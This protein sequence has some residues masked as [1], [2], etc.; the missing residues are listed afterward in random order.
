M[1]ELDPLPGDPNI[2]T[3][4]KALREGKRFG[5]RI[6]YY[7]L[8]MLFLPMVVVFFLRR[9]NCEYFYEWVDKDTF[10]YFFSILVQVASFF[11]VLHYLKEYSIID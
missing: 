10:A 3:F 5:N 2:C 7:F 4:L 6:I 11:I 1:F 9:G 8:G